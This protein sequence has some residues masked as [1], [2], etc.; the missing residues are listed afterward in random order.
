M[1][2]V[3]S[4]LLFL[5]MLILPS[6]LPAQDYGVQDSL[7]I[8]ENLRQE[9]DELQRS[10]SYFNVREQPKKIS[11]RNIEEEKIH[12]IKTEEDYWYADLQPEKKKEK[13]EQK[14]FLQGDFFKTLFWI[15][16]TGGFAALLIWFLA[17]GNISLFKR[18]TQVNDEEEDALAGAE[19]IFAL[20]Y[21]RDIEKAVNGGNFRL[22]V[23]L[24]YL[25]T[26]KDMA[27]KNII[28]YSHEKT[29]SDY[30][31]QLAKSRYY[32]SFFRLTRHFDYTWYGQF[33]LTPEAFRSVQKEFSSF[34]QQLN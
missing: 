23:R 1:V 28:R 12:S 16:L 21:D 25:Q 18:R 26:L 30:L 22:A 4:Y 14:N 17:S 3:F 11:E 8:E 33:V 27:E 32:K 15:L 2:K 7:Y 9:E 34:K 24:L 31:F 5:G 6:P 20:N 29:N 19:D 13:P 10:G